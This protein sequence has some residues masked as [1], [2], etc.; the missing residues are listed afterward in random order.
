MRLEDRLKKKP[1]DEEARIQLLSY[2]AGPPANADFSIVKAARA[3][4]ILWLIE[5]DPKSGLGLFQSGTGIYRLNCRGDDLADPDAFGLANQ[6]W[7]EQIRKNPGSPEIRRSAVTAIQFCSPEQAEQ[8][9]SE[10][11]D[12][13]WLGQL[14]ATAVLGITGESYKN[15]DPA[16]SDAEFRARP[17]ADKARRVLE[18]AT[19]KD[20]LVGAAQGLLRQ[21]AILWADGKLDWDYTALGNALLA[22]ARDLAPDDVTLMTLPTALPARGERPPATITIGGNMQAARL[23][24]NVPP[25]YPAEARDRGIE[26]TVQLT[27]LIGLDGKILHLRVDSG[28]AELISSAVEAVRQWEYRPTMLNGKPCYIQTRIDV[29]YKLSQR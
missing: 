6:R 2:Y 22:R 29:N 17:F 15:N 16:G 1:A 23:V 11:H 8:I 26:G 10:A 4:H 27:V 14:Y 13:R 19:D 9:L 21:G 3:T 25:V 18:Q 20:V 12:F 24:R 28:A 5:N 7:L